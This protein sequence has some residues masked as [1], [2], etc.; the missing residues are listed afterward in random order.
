M[1]NPAAKILALA[2]SFPTIR[3]GVV[4]FTE[5]NFDIEK[6]IGCMGGVSTS[7]RHSMLFIAA[8]WDN[9]WLI[10]QNLNFDVIEAMSSWDEEHRE[11]FIQWCQNPWWA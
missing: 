8:V 1:S 3:R 4:G 11:V 10:S 7:T 2:M 9:S 5:Q 6:F